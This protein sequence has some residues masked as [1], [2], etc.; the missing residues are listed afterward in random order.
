MDK[1]K[2]IPERS[3]V[4]EEDKW[5]L[6]R[7]FRNDSEWE[8]GLEKLNMEIGKI[9]SYRGQ[10]GADAGKLEEFLLF[11]NELGLLEE[12]LGYYSNLRLSEDG[13]D[14]RNQ[15]RYSKFITSATQGTGRNKF[16]ESRTSGNSG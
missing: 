16:H 7:L 6:E 9:A 4:N 15:E 5:D 12:K 14:S 11:M 8:K 13:G 2:K 10:L 1:I 3:E